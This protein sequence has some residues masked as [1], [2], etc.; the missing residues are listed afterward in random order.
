MPKQFFPIGTKPKRFDTRVSPERHLE[1]ENI[2][3]ERNIS[4]NQ[5]I[6]AALDLWLKEN[7]PTK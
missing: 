3:K 2:S 5:I 4:I 6:N 1:L 7:Q